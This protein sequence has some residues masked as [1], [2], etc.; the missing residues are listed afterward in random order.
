M[1][2]KDTVISRFWL[3]AIIM[4]AA[5]FAPSSVWAED[6]IE[7]VKVDSAYAD[8]DNLEISLVTCEPFHKIYS[9]Y[10]HTGLRI[11]NLK[12]GEDLLANWGIFDMTQ[13]FFP[14]KFAFGITDYRMAIES[15]PEFCARYQYYGSGV[16][17][18][19]LNLTRDEKARIMNAVAVNS[20]PENLFYRYNFFYDNCT[21]RVR[22]IIE[23]SIDGKVEYPAHDGESFRDLIHEWNAGHLWYRWGNNFLLGYNCDRN[24][25]DHERQFLP[26]NLFNDF[27]EAMIISNDSARKI[28]SSTEWAVPQQYVFAEN[29]F[30]DWVTSPT[31]LAIY[32]FV[33]FAFIPYIMPKKNFWKLDALLYLLSGIPGL[34]LFAMIFS[35]HP[36]V[37]LNF[38]IL[39]F[40]P[41]TMV[42]MWPI[43]K[44]ARK[45]EESKLAT[46]LLVMY[47][48][49]FAIGITKIQHF[50]DGVC[51]LALILII[52]TL[53]HA[54]KLR[55]GK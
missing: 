51:I 53:K 46:I 10:G 15:F 11:N 42:F 38:Q 28:V 14:V 4:T 1:K 5:L 7:E 55:N 33:I 44:K 22:D 30:F 54:P 6:E 25:T 12:T 9:L 37:S 49:G 19:V 21:T 43:L 17:V 40:N 39:V 16:K 50:A 20:L 29:S 41:L 34:I 27:D 32:L 45:D 52:R 23:A 31:A 48:I 36:T 2:I 13:S 47:A 18:Q 26:D 8:L 24:A 35:S 3:S